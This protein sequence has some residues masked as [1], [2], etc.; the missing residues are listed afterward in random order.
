MITETLIH[1]QWQNPMVIIGRNYVIGKRKSI[2]VNHEI[3]H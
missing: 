2:K 3:S 1:R